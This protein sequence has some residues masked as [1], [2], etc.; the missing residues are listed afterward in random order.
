MFD[1]IMGLPVH[2]LVVHVVVVLV[3]LAAIGLIAVA[4][5]PGWRRAYLPLVAACATVGFAAVPVATQSGQK[6]KQHLHASG[7]VADQ[8]HKHEQ[9]GKLVIFP[10]AAMWLLALALLWLDRRNGSKRA[11][12]IV[13]GLA[14]VAAL[15]A[16]AQVTVAGHLGSTAVW[17]CTIGAC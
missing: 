7:V 5:K 14:V 13:A 6:L 12:T 11:T 4:I 3:P 15:A 1:T 16:A 9:M 10:T 2:A 8:I 17:K